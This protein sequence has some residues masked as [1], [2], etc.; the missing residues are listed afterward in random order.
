[1]LLKKGVPESSNENSAQNETSQSTH[2]ENNVPENTRD[3]NK[4][5]EIT[6][7]E[8]RVSQD[9]QEENKVSQNTQEEPSPVTI[10]RALNSE[11]DKNLY[12][13]FESLYESVLFKKPDLLTNKVFVNA[14]NEIKVKLLHYLLAFLGPLRL[15]EVNT[16]CWFG[17]T[18]G[19]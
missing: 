6:R 11:Q 5:L 9:Q 2:E 17:P 18:P 14:M 7:E 15:G 19:G 8:N 4:A 16:S 1:M 10:E 3:E 13:E 12:S